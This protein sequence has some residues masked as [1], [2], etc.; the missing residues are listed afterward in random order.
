[1]NISNSGILWLVPAF[2]NSEFVP[3]AVKSYQMDTISKKYRC[4]VEVTIEAIGGKWKCVI[5]WWLRRDA[6]RFSELKL[7]L[8]NITQKVLTQQLRELEAEGLIGRES[9]KESPPRVEYFLTPHGQTLTPITELMCSWGKRHK[10]DYRFGYC[11]LQNVRVLVV[12][13]DSASLYVILQEHGALVVSATSIPEMLILLDG[14]CADVLLIDLALL[15]EENSQVLTAKIKQI[16]QQTEKTIAMV[17]IVP[18]GNVF[19]R[20]R[21]FRMGFAV[22]LPSPVEIQEMV[23]TVASLFFK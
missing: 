12:S 17:A 11:R 14:D 2:A 22:H 1:V 10:S 6:R 5:L 21:A 23:G 4:P 20:G 19:E 9:Y 8:P 16:E 18:V 3:H 15:N 7:L 13:N